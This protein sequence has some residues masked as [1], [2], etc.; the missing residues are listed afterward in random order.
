MLNNGGSAAGTC[1]L[2]D[3]PNRVLYTN[4]GTYTATAWV[5]AATPG[6]TLTLRLGEWTGPTAV[7]RAKATI[8][9]SPDWQPIKIRYTA[10]APGA[11][12]LDLSVYV[13]DAPPGSCFSA[14]DISIAWG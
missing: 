10:A 7:G 4:A 11:S 2:N 12:T 3:S 5:R 9:L 6:A 8:T 1:V 13:H 14:D